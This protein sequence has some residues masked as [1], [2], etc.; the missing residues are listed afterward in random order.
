MNK[1]AKI[2]FSE[3]DWRS[4]LIDLLIVTIGITIAFKLNTW[5][6]SKKHEHEANIYISSFIK[7][8]G[9][10]EERLLK[11]L[12]FS[13]KS[14]SDIDT[15]QSLLLSKR[16][17]DTRVEG[18]IATMMALT[19]FAPTT[20]TMENIN[21][22]GEFELI[23]DGALKESLIDTYNSYET[24][25]KLEGMLNDYLNNYVTP[26][27]F[28][29]IRF[30]S[31]KP[32]NDSFIDDPIFENIVIGYSV[33]LNQKISGYKNTLERVKLLDQDLNN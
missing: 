28:E 15:L 23:A 5:N 14:K 20:T 21:S 31:F 10:N 7:E 22:S 18:L 29:H 19:Q 1:Q 27:M 26:Y 13:Q 9:S 4:K 6:E 12:E 16:Y 32:I 33:L 3:I 17:S 11:A 2:R 25:H 24:S 8:N 30:S